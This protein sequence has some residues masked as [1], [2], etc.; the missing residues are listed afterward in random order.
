MAAIVFSPMACVQVQCQAS[1]D[2]FAK[3]VFVWALSRH[4]SDVVVLVFSR[5]QSLVSVLAFSR[6]QSDVVILAFSRHQSD[7]VILAISRQQSD[8]VVL[9]FLRHPLDVFILAACCA[10]PQA[11][12]KAV[13]CRMKA[14]HYQLLTSAVRDT[15]ANSLLHFVVIMM[16]LGRLIRLLGRLLHFVGKADGKAAAFH[17]KG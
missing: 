17:W 10:D 8:V 6:H 5:H 11:S 12:A 4:Q 9:A 13:D 1:L 16:T 14:V 7:V 3:T 2:A 15:E